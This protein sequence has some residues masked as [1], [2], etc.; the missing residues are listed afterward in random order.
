MIFTSVN[1][2]VHTG[3]TLEIIVS[4]MSLKDD[5]QYKLY[6]FLP[7]DMYSNHEILHV[8]LGRP[9]QTHEKSIGCLHLKVC[10]RLL[11]R[12]ITT[13]SLCLGLDSC[14]NSNS[15]NRYP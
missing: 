12:E 3:G 1:V 11:R 8:P 13:S 6:I 9:Q 15:C 5:F 10:W 4:Y 14:M 7:E 2:A